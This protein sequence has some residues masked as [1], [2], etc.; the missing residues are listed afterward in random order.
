MAM[1]LLVALAGLPL[2]APGTAFAQVP[3]ASSLIDANSSQYGVTINDGAASTSALDVTLT[4]RPLPGAVRMRVSN[5]SDLAGS[6]W[7]PFAS[8]KAWRLAAPGP[9]GAPVT[10]YVQSGNSTGDVSA[11][12]QDDITVR[13]TPRVSAATP[14]PATSSA[15]T[16]P[17]TSAAAPAS[18]VAVAVPD[19]SPRPRVV[20]NTELALGIPEEGGS[21]FVTVSTTG[22]GNGL[23]TV[24]FDS[25]TNAIVHAGSQQFQTAPFAVTMTPGQEPTSLMFTVQ[26]QTRGQATMVRLVIVDSCGEW[27]TFVGGGPNA[28]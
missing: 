9:S 21:M 6:S 20:V 7:E 19:C 10:V 5:S 1:V 18:N 2:G 15:T 16:P 28:F 12:Y 14:P 13:Q 27:S 22:S 25:F 24:R 4:M 11:I 17:A 26:R 3:A 23:R 8:R